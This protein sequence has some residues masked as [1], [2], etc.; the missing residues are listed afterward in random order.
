LM[1]VTRH[2]SFCVLLLLL[3]GGLAAQQRIPFDEQAQKAFD[4]GL[5]KFNTRAWESAATQ[6]ERVARGD[7][8]THRSTAAYVMAA[9]A[10]VLGGKYRSALR[11]VEEL[12]HRFPGS[13]YLAE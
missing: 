10:H 12:H 4:Y 3:A 9:R 5:L 7:P 2:S 6:F 1:E 13:R 8:P 11:L